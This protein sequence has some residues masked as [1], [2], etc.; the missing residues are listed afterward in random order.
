VR[1]ERVAE[2]RTRGETILP[3]G[4]LLSLGVHAVAAVLL[5]TEVASMTA[6]PVAAT[7]TALRVH[8]VSLPPAPTDAP[9]VREKK[10]S[11]APKAPVTVRETAA[12]K[13]GEEE[14][15]PSPVFLA[16]LAPVP[17]VTDA[18]GPAGGAGN[19][20][21]GKGAA[22][23]AKAGGGEA[24]QTVA[25]PR[26]HVNPQP[27]YP[28]LARLKG[29]EGVVLLS[30]EVLPDGRVGRLIVKTSSG[31]PLLDRSAL[32]GVKGWSFEPGR[33]RGIPVTMW[34]DVPVRFR[35]Q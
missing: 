7:P 33:R 16:S 8:L 10:P 14:K 11:A 17:V 29:Q 27:S 15:H 13:A 18:G 5:F 22:D 4:V 25:V 28:P 34:V 32:D 9:P 30:V 3:R 21:N 23:A 35:L 6:G 2:T 31:Y 19:A 12:G 26:Y 24:P 1:E 20:S